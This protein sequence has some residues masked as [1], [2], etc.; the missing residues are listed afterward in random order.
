MVVTIKQLLWK[1]RHIFMI[2]HDAKHTVHT[3]AHHSI[4]IS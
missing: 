4:L 1:L 2:L 3:A